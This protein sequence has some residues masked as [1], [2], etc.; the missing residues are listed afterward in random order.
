M[1]DHE[2][3]DKKN[4]KALDEED[5]NV[6]KRYVSNTQLAQLVFNGAGLRLD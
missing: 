6:L 4:P 3:D 1:A 2:E 5:I